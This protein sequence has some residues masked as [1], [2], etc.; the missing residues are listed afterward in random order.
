MNGTQ[1]LTAT[2]T[3]KEKAPKG[4]HHGGALILIRSESKGKTG[5]TNNSSR[6]PCGVQVRLQFPSQIGDQ[7]VWARV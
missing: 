2:R 1:P 7:Q 3:H 6:P 5:L 4:E